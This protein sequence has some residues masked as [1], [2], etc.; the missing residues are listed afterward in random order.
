VTFEWAGSD[1]LRYSI[2]VLG[3]QGLLW[4]QADLPR[5][6]FTYPEAAPALRAGVRYIW[7]LA[8]R[9]YPVQRTQF[10]LLPSAEAG[11]VH[12]ALAL[13]ESGMLAS[14]PQNTMLLL[15]AGLLLQEGLYHEARR[16]LLAGIAA[17]PEEPTL[18]LLQGRVYERVGLKELAAEAFAE[19][20]LRSTRQP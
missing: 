17:A 8:A 7:E 9:G 10:E 16:E 20:R 15:R 11:R 19:A 3:P 4:E 6:P 12:A 2:R 5:Q 18:H 1:R 14:Y 13:L